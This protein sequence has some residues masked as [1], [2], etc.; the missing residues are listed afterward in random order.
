MDDPDSV[1][2]RRFMEFEDQMRHEE[3]RETEEWFAHILKETMNPWVDSIKDKNIREEREGSI[4]SI[5]LSRPGQVFSNVQ[6]KLEE[7]AISLND[8]EIPST[9]LDLSYLLGFY[10]FQFR[11]DPDKRPE[12]IDLKQWVLEAADASG[13]MD[14]LKCKYTEKEIYSRISHIYCEGYGSENPLSGLVKNALEKSFPGF[15]TGIHE[16]DVYLKIVANKIKEVFTKRDIGLLKVIKSSLKEGHTDSYKRELMDKIGHNFEEDFKD[17]LK[18]MT[19]LPKFLKDAGNHKLFTTI[20]REDFQYGRTFDEFIRFMSSEMKTVSEISRNLENS[21]YKESILFPIFGE[22]EPGIFYDPLF[23]TNLDRLVCEGQCKDEKELVE[24]ASLDIPNYKPMRFAGNG[25]TFDVCLVERIMQKE[26]SHDI[27]E[28]LLVPKKEGSSG[29]ISGTRML[30][31]AGSQLLL[32]RQLVCL[33]ELLK[34]VKGV[35]RFYGDV[36]IKKDCRKLTSL[37]LEYIQGVPLNEFLKDHIG[38]LSNDSLSEEG[39]K[40]GTRI[41]LEYMV[42]TLDVLDGVNSAGVVHNDFSPNNVLVKSNGDIFIIDYAISSSEI[43]DPLT[44]ASRR[45]SSQELLSKSK[46]TPAS[47]IYSCGTILYHFLKGKHPINNDSDEVVR[48][49]SDRESFEKA[50]RLID[51]DGIPDVLKEVISKSMNYDPT[52]RYQSAAELKTELEQALHAL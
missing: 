50:K 10:N 36:E 12:G 29:H 51:F 30:T 37:R 52:E 19:K 24:L 15:E 45:Y 31:E 46:V 9:R 23:L 47:D 22:C 39:R 49:V 1:N 40:E 4:S 2:P 38:V 33:H 43:M 28:I 42:R 7:I 21:Q 26:K 32:E 35:P 14:K 44:Y 27:Y 8:D 25:N 3:K 48:I 16:F 34:N 6:R 41:I 13:V 11:P 5:V 17:A 18:Y 20:L